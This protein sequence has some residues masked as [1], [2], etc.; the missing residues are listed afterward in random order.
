MRRSDQGTMEST[1]S[2]S[3]GVGPLR[4]RSAI[5]GAVAALAMG[6][7]GAGFS[8]CGDDDDEGPAE[9]AGQAVDEAGQEAGQEIEEETKDAKDKE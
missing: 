9:E 1:T 2:G 4:R 5:A 3:T 8:A 7:A 6:F